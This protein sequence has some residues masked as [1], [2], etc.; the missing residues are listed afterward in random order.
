MNYFILLSLMAISMPAFS[1][2]DASEFDLTS[3]GISQDLAKK[4]ENKDLIKDKDKPVLTGIQKDRAGKI[5]QETPEWNFT[6]IRFG[7][8]KLTFEE[9]ESADSLTLGSRQVADSF[10]YDLNYN[11]VNS[12]TS[13]TN[14]QTVNMGAGWQANWAHRLKPYIGMQL[15]YSWMKSKK[16]DVSDTGF[17]TGLDAGL[18]IYK[19]LPFLFMVGTRYGVHNFGNNNFKNISTQEVYFSLGLESF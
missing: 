18:I 19:K 14:L 9:R 4:R 17:Y 7:Q 2:E 16:L 1:Q 15:G 8:N 5:N 10:Y 12:G 13:K 11:V 6:Y 3:T